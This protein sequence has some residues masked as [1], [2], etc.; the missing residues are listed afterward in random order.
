[1]E[2][3]DEGWAGWKEECELAEARTDPVEGEG[4][5]PRPAEEYDVDAA[6]W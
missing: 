6:W 4:T 1:M 5:P 3:E 2:E